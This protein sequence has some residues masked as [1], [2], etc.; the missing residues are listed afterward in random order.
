MAKQNNVLKIFDLVFDSTRCTRER[1]HQMLQS[2]Q[3]VGFP[4]M[5]A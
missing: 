1:D 2:V 4:K 3:N 5:Y